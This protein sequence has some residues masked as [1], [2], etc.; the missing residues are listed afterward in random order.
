MQVM[1]AAKA[2][3]DKVIYP[4]F[5]SPKLDG[6]RIMIHDRQVMTRSWK[7]L[8]NKVI[9]Q[10]YG[11]RQL[12]GL[13]GELIVGGPTQ[14]DVF[15]TTSSA[16]MSR[17]GVPNACFY[18]FDHYGPGCFQNRLNKAE[19]LVRQAQVIDEL[20]IMI[21]GHTLVETREQLEA[22]EQ[23]F[24]DS[25]YEGLMIRD[26]GGI[27]KEGRSTAKE[28]GL[29]KLKRF[30]DSEAV[31][32]GFTQLMH[33]TNEAKRNATG[34]LERSSKKEGLVG[35]AQLGALVV[36]DLKTK[37]EFEIGTGFNLAERKNLWEV[38]AALKG[39]VV[40]YK[41]FAGGIKDKPRFPSYQGFRDRMDM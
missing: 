28:G 16:V 34:N 17:D 24:I 12:E 15:R 23:Q 38:R 26:P 1:L 36:R 20:R 19:E 25:G 33:N 18:V 8:P 40:K 7:L 14:P 9:Q 35:L 31:V 6:V 30:E 3:L 32:I 11:L 5:V 2:D 22:K 27:Y 29:L 21:V 13:D 41:Y 10:T 4:V 39:K 37:V